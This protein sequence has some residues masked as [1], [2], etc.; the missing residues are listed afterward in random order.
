MSSQGV[1]VW[2]WIALVTGTLV[3][4][5]VWVL[6]LIFR[7]PPLLTQRNRQTGETSHGAWLWLLVLVGPLGGIPALVLFGRA[8]SA[9]LAD[10]FWLLVWPNLW[11]LA[12]SC[13]AGAL[14]AVT[15]LALD[16]R[17]GVLADRYRIWSEVA[18]AQQTEQQRRSGAAQQLARQH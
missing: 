10:A 12:V 2:W 11:L 15:V 6:V 1:T 16:H 18:Q 14:V 13:G 3:G 9:A 17:R 8:A 4:L 7:G 5:A